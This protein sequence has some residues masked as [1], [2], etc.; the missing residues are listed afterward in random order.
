MVPELTITDFFASPNF[1]TNVLS[2]SVIS[3]R[4]EPNFACV[5]LGEAQ[6][7]VE[8]YHPGAWNTAELTRPLGRG[9]NFQI[10][11]DDIKQ[12]FD[13]VSANSVTLYLDL[14]ENLYSTG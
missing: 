9:V 2:F 1:Y 4:T 6:L 7:M 5:C 10:E 13:R 8:Q 11:V 3:R 12:I 14:R